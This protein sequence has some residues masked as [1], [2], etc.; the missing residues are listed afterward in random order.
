MRQS[1][2]KASL[3]RHRP[4]RVLRLAG[5]C[6]LTLA[7]LP[8]LAANTGAHGSTR[9]LQ[10]RA[11]VPPANP[12][13]SS[14]TFGYQGVRNNGYRRPLPTHAQQPRYL[15]TEASVQRPADNVQMQGP[16]ATPRDGSQYNIIS[17]PAP[18]QSFAG[19]TGTP[20]QPAPALSLQ[21]TD[22]MRR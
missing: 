13:P 3:A 11:E 20:L 8:V 10:M 2:P 21:P 14:T 19:T 12:N 18:T 15:P 16:V 17:A 4:A 7:T 9:S 6:L 22:A 5:L 1:P